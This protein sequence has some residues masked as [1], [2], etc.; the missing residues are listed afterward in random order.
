MYSPVH[1]IF[2]LASL[3]FAIWPAPQSYTTGNSVLWIEPGVKVSYNG[4]NVGCSIVQSAISRNLK[5][6][7]TKGLVPWK[8]VARDELSQFEPD[9]SSS[10]IF[11]TNLD[12]TQTAP[13][14]MNTYKPLAGDVDES[15]N[16]TITTDG[17]ASISAVSSTGVLH[18][19]Q[20]FIQLFYKQSTGAGMYTNLAPVSIIDAPKF[21]HRGLN[22]DVARNWYEVSDIKRTIDAL[23]MNK[24]NRLHLHMTDSQ[25]WP[26]DIPALPDLSKKGAYATGLSYTPGDIK[27]IQTYA[28][29]RGIEVIIEFDMPGHTTAI[30]LSYPD[31][32]AGINAQPWSTYCDEV[33]SQ[34]YL[35]DET[36]KSNDTS[37]IGPLIQKL[38]DRNHA[39]LRQAG[40]T[41]IV[42]E[43][44]LLDWNLTLG[45]DV[46]VQSW[47][48]DASVASIT[49]LGH[50]AL[51]GNYNFWYLDC[52]K[53]QWLDFSNGASFQTY[54]PFNDYCSPTKNWRLVYSYDP[55]GGVPA[56]QTH[57]VQGGEVHI[58]SEQT[59]PVNL[60]DMVWPRASAAGE[61]LWSGRQD[62][63]GQNR[64]QIEASP[65]LAEMRE[66]MVNTGV[67]VGPVQMIFC[68]QSNATEFGAPKLRRGRI[69]E[70]NMI[71]EILTHV[72]GRTLLG[73]IVVVGLLW[74]IVQW[75][76]TSRKI[77]ALGER[78]YRVRTWLPL[79]IDLI[80]RAVHGTVTH[81]NLETWLYWFT[82]PQGPNFTVEA[83]PAGRRVIFTADPENIKAILA[84]QFTDYGKGEPFHREWKDFLGDSIFVTDLETWHN[85]RQLIRPQFIKDRVSDLEV[86]ER[87]VQVLIREI[88]GK[89]WGEKEGGEGRE[90]D[91]S[92]LFF[93]YTLDA[94]T[95]FLLGRS[96][97]SLEVPE[98]EFAEAFGEVQRV[99]NII[100][101]AG[102]LNPLVPRSTFKKGIR[103]INEFV[104]PF[105]DDALR[106]SPEELAS[107]TK[108]EEGYTFLHALASF[109]RDRTV[110]RDQLVAVLLAGRDTTAST[111]SWLFYELARHPEVM[112]KLRAEIEERIGWE[113]APTYEDLKNMKYLQNTMNETLRLY[114][115]VP[116]NVRL[117]LKD[118]TLPRGGG[119]DGLSPVGILKDTPIGY[120]TL[121]MQRRPDLT[122]HITSPSSS[123]PLT[124]EHFSP[125][126]W[127]TWQ[128]KPWNYIPFNGGPRICIGQ[129]FALTEMG[130]TV[131][132]LLQRYEGLR[133]F[134]GE[135]DGGR[136]CL[137]AE[138]VLQPGE[139]VRVG[140]SR[141][142]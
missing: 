39:Q 132:R 40:L 21:S 89:S 54:Y 42:W 119:P 128:P 93:R 129:Q 17:K 49:A 43:E 86:F 70:E 84:T 131:V 7:F 76:D 100:A 12:I 92:D 107:K 4:G 58:W 64:S 65:R 96:V 112:K 85:S 52:G 41:P 142:R 48:S 34:V 67:R 20:S 94:A 122:P 30:G 91:V 60:D 90:L 78:A 29:E 81:K 72:K 123:S 77:R 68:T 114:P 35:L 140:F 61:V 66:R 32:I 117:A 105:I 110:L 63:S 13:D 109:T 80:A 133:N 97:N 108:S 88:D 138:I 136:P 127:Q 26:M 130:Y 36:V 71:E 2:I 11:I 139:G 113:R 116:F 9:A 5:T 104:N 125:E 87:H 118:T 95:D 25:S 137:K 44:M 3:V 124:V 111:L 47:L 51:A 27:D 69:L 14:Q 6:L 56:N 79:D 83:C 31:L 57:L 23:A 1:L 121:V 134:M 103:T 74:K 18:G 45:S 62:A 46:L 99:Q 98:Q 106:L 75:I 19:L 24:F 15:Y 73:G 115:V 22:M 59:D 37:V 33:N 102:P 28:I 141:R 82:T 126:R 10:K 135:V 120:S 101:R 38:V 55:L 8:L 50:K 16:L 53:G